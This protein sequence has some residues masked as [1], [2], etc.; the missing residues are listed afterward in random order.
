MS[1]SDA[2]VFISGASINELFDLRD[3][4]DRK[5]EERRNENRVKIWHAHC[6]GLS[7]GFSTTER[8]PELFTFI[9]QR[10]KGIEEKIVVEQYFC[11]VS[12]VENRLDQ[13]WYL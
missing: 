3:Q 10:T 1:Y 7:I 5:V 13:D 12:E 6:D 8:L 9:A 4:I 2:S 11:I